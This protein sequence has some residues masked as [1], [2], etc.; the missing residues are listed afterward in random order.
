MAREGPSESRYYG[1]SALLFFTESTDV[2]PIAIDLV[3][4]DWPE[5]TLVGSCGPVELL[6]DR[7][8]VNY[9]WDTAEWRDWWD[10][11]GAEL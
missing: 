10:K 6:R 4:Q 2:V 8:A 9:F 11:V 5:D 7:F 3:D 1:C